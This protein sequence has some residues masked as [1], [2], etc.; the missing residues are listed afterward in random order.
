MAQSGHQ[1]RM[2]RWPLLGVKRTSQ[3]R[4]VMSEILTCCDL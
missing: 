1:E 4:P 3:I 2:D